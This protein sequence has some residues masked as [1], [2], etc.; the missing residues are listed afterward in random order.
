MIRNGDDDNKRVPKQYPDALMHFDFQSCTVVLFFLINHVH[1][2]RVPH[3][4]ALFIKIV[5]DWVP[6]VCPKSGNVLVPF[7]PKGYYFG[8]NVG[9]S[10]LHQRGHVIKNLWECMLALGSM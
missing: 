1:E 5:P 9:N 8:V 4:T 3:S 7:L 10:T 6:C 2:K